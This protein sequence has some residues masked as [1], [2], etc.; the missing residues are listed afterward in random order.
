MSFQVPFEARGAQDFPVFP[1]E[2]G[3]EYTVVDISDDG[4]RFACE[5]ADG[6]LGWF[7]VKYV[8]I[9]E[10]RSPQPQQ[11]TNYQNTPTQAYTSSPNAFSKEHEM[12]KRQAAEKEKR[13]LELQKKLKQTPKRPD[14][15]I[16]DDEIKNA[17][18]Q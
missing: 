1:I 13:R 8:R 11:R 18:R 6:S 14:N 9:L 15:E 12:A 2:E 7:P 16:D 17:S 3:I 10:T 4:T 5:C